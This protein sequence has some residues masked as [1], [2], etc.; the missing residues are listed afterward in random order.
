MTNTVMINSSKTLGEGDDGT[1]QCVT[2]TATITIPKDT[3]WL[4]KIGDLI[5]IS[6]N[7]TGIVSIAAES[8]HVTLNAPGTNISPQY[9][10]AILEKIDS[11][12]WVA[13]GNLST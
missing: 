5:N 11:N 6:A 12:I 9:G 1:L 13:W 2:A 8:T 7:T 4:F 10:R 3:T